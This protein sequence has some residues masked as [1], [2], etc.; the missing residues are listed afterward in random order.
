MNLDTTIQSSHTYTITDDDVLDVT[1]PVVSITAPVN[2]STISGKTILITANA[3][4]DIGVSGVQFKIDG[5]NQEAEDVMAPYGIIWNSTTVT[6]GQHIISAM[7]R[8]TT[9]NYAT[10]TIVINVNNLNIGPMG[11]GG[12]IGAQEVLK[13]LPAAS[14][15]TPIIKDVHAPGK[16]SPEIILVQ[17]ILNMDPTTRIAKVGP[18]SPGKETNLYGPATKAA[19]GK[20]QIKYK[21]LKSPKDKGYGIVGPA[22]RKKMNELLKVK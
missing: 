7:A 10:S 3:S 15:L 19:V 14:P 22:T 16:R 9:G 6:D 5:I 18:G 21:I 8:D 1:L 20:F 2:L 12:I 4:D 11:G 13:I 17:K